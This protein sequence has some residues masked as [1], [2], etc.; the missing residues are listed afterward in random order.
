MGFGFGSGGRGGVVGRVLGS[1]GRYGKGGWVRFGDCGLSP[2]PKAHG[3][4]GVG[5]P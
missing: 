5:L 3:W 1:G 4:P 2:S